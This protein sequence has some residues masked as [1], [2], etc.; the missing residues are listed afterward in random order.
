[1]AKS[2][3][4]QMSAMR[5]A[6]KREARYPM[7]WRLSGACVQR[8]GSQRRSERGDKALVA[9]ISSGSGMAPGGWLV[10]DSVWFIGSSLASVPSF[11]GIVHGTC[12]FVQVL[13]PENRP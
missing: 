8:N 2:K 11:E 9:T 3:I 6:M 5:G 13:F 4:M 10:A 12:R 1:M 7:L